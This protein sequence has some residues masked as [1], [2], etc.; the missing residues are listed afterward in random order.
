MLPET[1]KHKKRRCWHPLSCQLHP[2]SPSALSDLPLNFYT[3]TFLMDLKLSFC[4]VSLNLISHSSVSHVLW[5]PVQTARPP[6]S[7]S[8]SPSS[9]LPRFPILHPA[10]CLGA[11]PCT[12]AVWPAVNVASCSILLGSQPL[13]NQGQAPSRLWS[14]YNFLFLSCFWPLCHFYSSHLSCLSSRC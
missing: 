9:H 2:H 6:P 11:L 13:C 12:P 1:N 7:L 4:I 10:L 8:L 3:L 14:L 5:Q